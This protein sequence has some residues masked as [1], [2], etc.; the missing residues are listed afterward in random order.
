MQR[1][2]NIKYNPTDEQVAREWMGK[3]YDGSPVN[4]EHAKSQDALFPRKERQP[5][6]PVF[7]KR[8]S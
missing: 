6:R 8:K 7:G 3:T 4:V 5:Q 2:M 1:E